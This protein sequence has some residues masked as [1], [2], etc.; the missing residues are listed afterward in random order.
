MHIR[1]PWRAINGAICKLIAI[2]LRVAVVLLI[3]PIDFPLEGDYLSGG[4]SPGARKRKSRDL[5][6]DL[7]FRPDGVLSVVSGGGVS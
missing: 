2:V 6:S 4:D 7:H 1:G 5:K 3:S